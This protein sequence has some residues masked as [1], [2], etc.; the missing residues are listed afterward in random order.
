[1]QGDIIRH[2]KTGGIH[3]L[4]ATESK[5]SGLAKQLRDEA[6][7][8]QGQLMDTFARLMILPMTIISKSRSHGAH[9]VSML[10]EALLLAVM[11]QVSCPLQAT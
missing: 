6:R 2:N 1:M 11:L 10:G 3:A 8:A 9:C 5:T 4:I 7:A